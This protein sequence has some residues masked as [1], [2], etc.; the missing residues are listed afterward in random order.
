MPFKSEKQRRWMHINE[1]EIAKRWEE[2][3][4]EEKDSAPKMKKKDLVEY[5]KFKENGG[6]KKY[7]K[8]DLIGEA[9]KDKYDFPRLREISAKEK[10]L[11]R[12]YLEAIRQ[13]GLINMFGAYPI[14]NWA[15]SDLERWLYGQRMDL[16]SLE[17]RIENLEYDLEYEGEDSGITEGE[18]EGARERKRIIEYLLDNKREVR[19]VLIR[20]ALGRISATDNNHETHN[21]Q[22]VFEKMAKEAWDHWA[23]LLSI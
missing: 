6:Y 3:Y 21:V 15:K 19:D 17:Q 12:N 18:I 10:K 8:S 9:K 11:L 14:L 16:E 13:S 5:I 2:I 7:K 22:R 23:S 1:P 20:A 4:E